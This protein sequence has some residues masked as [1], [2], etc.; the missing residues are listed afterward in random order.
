M[1]ALVGIAKKLEADPGGIFNPENGW[2]LPAP[3]VGALR[4]A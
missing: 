4:A 3:T 1:P 2:T